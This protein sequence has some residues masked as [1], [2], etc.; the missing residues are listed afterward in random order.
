MLA[1]A[2]FRRVGREPSFPCSPALLSRELPRLQLHVLAAARSG[3]GRR[4]ARRGRF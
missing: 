4:S 1:H 3:R 2:V